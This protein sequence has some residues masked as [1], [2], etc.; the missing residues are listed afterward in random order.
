[1]PVLGDGFQV[2][3]LTPEAANAFIE[4]GGPASGSPLLLL[5][6]RQLGGALA[7]PGGGAGALGALPDEFTLF[8]V[9]IVMG[10][11]MAQAIGARLER[12]K[13]TM[14]PW[15]AGVFLNF[16]ETKGGGA[17]RAF[18]EATYARLRDVKARY[19]EDDRFRSNHPVEPALRPAAT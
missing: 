17:P 13:E 15:S 18:D 2:R 16:C 12:V 4:V 5:E 9:G 14:A 11:E 8:G 10:P 7:E 1:V 6:L 3:E 19:D